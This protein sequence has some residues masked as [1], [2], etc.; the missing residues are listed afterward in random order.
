MKT[1]IGDECARL[2][3]KVAELEA[4]KSNASPIGYISKADYDAAVTAARYTAFT[5]AN[6]LVDLFGDNAKCYGKARPRMRH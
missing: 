3:R 5:K 4:Q 1:L 6:R 2:A